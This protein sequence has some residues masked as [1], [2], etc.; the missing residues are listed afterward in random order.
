MTG[1]RLIPDYF[2]RT[3]VGSYY[4][5]SYGKDPFD[6]LC[7]SHSIVQAEYSAQSPIGKTSPPLVTNVKLNATN[8][9]LEV[10]GVTTSHTHLMRE[11]IK[12]AESRKGEAAKREIP[13]F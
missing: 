12:L 9:Q 10:S 11:A 8:R 5:S 13:K 6:G 4:H 3:I 1:Q 2:S 7:H